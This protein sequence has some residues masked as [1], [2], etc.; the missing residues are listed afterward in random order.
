[1]SVPLRS[2][3]GE[4]EA[5]ETRVFGGHGWCILWTVDDL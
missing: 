5:A 1:M 2:A 3:L 4:R